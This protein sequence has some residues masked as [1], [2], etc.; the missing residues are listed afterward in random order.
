MPNA[1]TTRVAAETPT[2]LQGD[3][4]GSISIATLPAPNPFVPVE[5]GN[6]KAND[7]ALPDA[8]SPKLS[9]ANT[10]YNPPGLEVLHYPSYLNSFDSFVVSGQAWGSHIEGKT[11]QVSIAGI[12]R[13]SRI[14]DGL[15][16]VRFE[17][18]AI[19]RHRHGTREFVAVLRDARG[20]TARS[21]IHVDIE[22]FTEGYV[23]IDD[24]FA[25]RD[26]PTGSVLVTTGELALGTH[27]Y[28]RELVVVL[29]NDD[30]ESTVITTGSI[31]P[32]WRFGEWRAYIP[33]DD[34]P[35]G[36]YKVRAQL[37]D[38]AN[39]ALTHIAVS[40]QAFSIN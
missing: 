15:W 38:H 7:V 28:G 36:D 34:V 6:R 23:Q 5:V 24:Y 13:T 2:D 31:N 30:E 29:V 27:D 22:E 14:I 10:T 25:F 19:P 37:M 40:S 8:D 20:N 21:A 32:G 39:A 9:G 35:P 1:S 18:G 4:V 17:D 12:T 26:T 16:S 3:T 33:V 11:V